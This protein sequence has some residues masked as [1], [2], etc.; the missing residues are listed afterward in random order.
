MRKRTD[1][2]F[3]ER[4]YAIVG[5]R[6]RT[7]RKRRNLSPKELGKTINVSGRAM[8]AYEIG[9]RRISLFD[10]LRIATLFGWTV[11]EMIFSG[12]GFVRELPK[13]TLRLIKS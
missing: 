9:A 13:S 2:P 4:F 6:I 12:T 1:D 3:G 7:E 5:D 10:A 11:D 8:E